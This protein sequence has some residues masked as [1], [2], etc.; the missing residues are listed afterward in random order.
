MSLVRD[1]NQDVAHGL[2][3]FQANTQRLRQVSDVE[4]R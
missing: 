2:E 3:K 1:K 4:S